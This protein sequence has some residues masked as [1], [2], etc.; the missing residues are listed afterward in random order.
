VTRPVRARTQASTKKD[1]SAIAAKKITTPG[2]MAE[3]QGGIRR[4]NILVYGRYK[5][6]KTRFCLTAGRGKVLVVDPERGTDRFIKANPHVWHLQAWEETDDLYKYLRSGD[7]P[8][9]YVAIDGLSR[10]HNMALRFVRRVAEEADLNRRSGQTTQRDYGNA[11]EL[12][13]GLF[14]NL[15]AL[16]L[17]VIY[18]AQE[19]V[20]DGAE[21]EEDADVEIA[22]IQYVPDVPKGSRAAVNSI[23]DVIGRLYTVKVPSETGE[24]NVVRRRL[25]LAPSM[26]YDTGARS[27]FKLPDYLENPTVP[28]LVRLIEEGKTK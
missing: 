9:E 11:N 20:I 18:T 12:L 7:H 14:Y 2:A 17:G 25:W 24:G 16:P 22:N 28:R 3:S 1:Y 4:P 19:R 23:V 21:E 15:H 8:Y 5:K 6:G 13:K 26:S 10:I 27:E